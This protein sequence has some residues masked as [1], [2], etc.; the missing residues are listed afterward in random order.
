VPRFWPAKIAF[1]LAIPLPALV[2]RLAGI[3]LGPLPSLFVFGSA[4]V[5]A[6]FILAWAAEAAQKDISASLAVAILALVAVLPEYAVD[7]FFAYKSG[8][9]PEFAAFAAANMTGSNRLLLGLGWP[10]ITFV[11]A[12]K[13]RQ[14]GSKERSLRLEPHRKVEL[15]FLGVAAVYSFLI[16]IK[17]SISLI[18]SVVLLSLFGLYLFRVSRERK[19]DHEFVGVPAHLAGLPRPYRPLFVGGLFLAAAAFVLVAAEPFAN[20]LVDTGAAFGIDKF[21]LVQWLAPLASE[22]PEFIVAIL[23]ALRMRGDDAIGTLLSAKVNQWTLLVGSL[24]VAHLAG[25]GGFALGLDARQVEEFLLTAAQTVLGISVLVNLRFSVKEGLVLLGLFAL[26]FPFPQ[27]SVRLGFTGLY[28]AIAA[29]LLVMNRG[30][31][32]GTGRALWPMARSPV[33]GSVEVEM[34]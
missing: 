30:S 25:G 24:A 3:H 20:A 27:T 34:K 12:W 16:P 9:Q 21:L 8:G 17:G 19:T 1:A 4:V 33:K 10:L 32:L 23:L 31:L 14:A 22:A 29:A 15:A 7:L 28:L 18:D 6:A 2:F 5:G 11:F 26:Q 13:C